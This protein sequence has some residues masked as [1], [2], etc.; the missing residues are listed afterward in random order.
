MTRLLKQVSDNTG[1]KT[2]ALIG[3]AVAPGSIGIK[4]GSDWPGRRCRFQ[5]ILEVR[6][7]LCLAKRLNQSSGKPLSETRALIGQ[8]GEVCFWKPRY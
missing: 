6:Y 2:Q 1:R 5:R 8:V 3:Q 4:T 7:R